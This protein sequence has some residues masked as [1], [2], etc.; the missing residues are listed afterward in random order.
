MPCD[1]LQQYLESF[2]THPS[3]YGYT[4]NVVATPVAERTGTRQPSPLGAAIKMLRQRE[5]MT[6]QD[7]A[8]RAGVNRSYI[9]LLENGSRQ[10]ASAQIVAALARALHTTPTEIY[11][12]AG[13]FDLPPASEEV[14]I[15][16]EGEKPSVLRRIADLPL[17]YLIEVERMGRRL[18]LESVPPEQQG[19]TDTEGDHGR[20]PG[21]HE[22][23]PDS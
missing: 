21:P 8:E 13:M 10:N 6:Q 23:K 12:L 14:V 1:R 16:G 5:E 9:T 2:V 15:T 19:D 18:F 11:R 22:P 4:S 7:L 17:Q 3:N 20:I